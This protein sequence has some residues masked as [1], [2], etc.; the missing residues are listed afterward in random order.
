MNPLAVFACDPGRCD[1]TRLRRGRDS[2]PPFPELPVYY[3]L[4][5]IPLAL[6]AAFFGL[7]ILAALAGSTG[8]AFTASGGF[9]GPTDFAETALGDFGD[10]AGLACIAFAV[11]AGF[12]GFA[13]LEGFGGMGSGMPASLRNSL[14]SCWGVR[15]FPSIWSKNNCS[16]IFSNF[17]PGLAPMA[18]NSARGRRARAIAYLCRKFLM[19]F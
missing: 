19:R 5:F 16:R 6:E 7:G 13:F 2:S 15:I 12:A 1:S 11:L 14:A 8:L 17:G 4:F 9:A 3:F 10:S 18:R